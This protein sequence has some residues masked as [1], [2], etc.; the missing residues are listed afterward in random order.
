M[1]PRHRLIVEEH[2]RYLHQLIPRHHDDDD[3]RHR[4]LELA[5]GQLQLLQVRDRRERLVLVF[6]ARR[7]LPDD[8]AADA[9]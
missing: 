6:E 2:D 4:G 5:V 3:L 8:A 7:R 9:E 1:L